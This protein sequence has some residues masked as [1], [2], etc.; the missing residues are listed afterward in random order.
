MTKTELANMALGHLGVDRAIA[1]L[2]T[3]QSRDAKI[4]RMYY[5]NARRQTLRDFPFPCITVITDLALVEP[6][7][8]DEWKYSYQY[9]AD[10]LQL[11]R[12]PNGFSRIDTEKTKVPYRVAR[13]VSGKVVYTN[14]PNAKIEYTYN[15]TNIDRLD[16]DVVM[17]MSLRLAHYIAPKLTGGDPFKMGQRAL[18]LYYLEGSKASSNALNEEQKD[19][20]IDADIIRA[21]Y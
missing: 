2:D 3:E 21:R 15:E 8:N 14:M 11:R 17:V 1:D 13:G 5:E 6:D 20:D 10:C 7:P 19:E 9:P 16:D 12:I 4:I 18:Q